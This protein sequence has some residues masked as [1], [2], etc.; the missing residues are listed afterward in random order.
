MA[1]R[2]Q[3]LLSSFGEEEGTS[4]F[5]YGSTATPCIRGQRESFSTLLTESSLSSEGSS[6]QS[7]PSMELKKLASR[8]DLVPS[9]EEHEAM[10]D[11]GISSDEEIGKANEKSDNVVT[12]R[13]FVWSMMKGNYKII[14]SCCMWYVSY[15][16]MSVLG[17]TVAFMHFPRT[18]LPYPRALPDYGY[19]VIPEWCPAVPHVPH[20]NVQSCI[21]LVLYSIIWSGICIRWNRDGKLILQQMLHLNTLVFLTRTTTVSVTGLPQPNPKC[22]AVQAFPVTYQQAWEFVVG[23][24]FPPHACGDLIYSGHVACTLVCMTIMH[25]HGFLCNRY[26]GIIVWGLACLGIFATLSC[27]S[28]YTV[29]VVLACYFVLFLKEFYFLRSNGIVNGTLA[30][31]IQWIERH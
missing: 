1:A 4:L 6:T 9:D 20:G 3:Q 30:R 15:M 8:S 10:G 23:R 12:E 21:L 13:H 24:G 7:S 22:T 28:H 27:R 16:I 2:E 17:G 26:I 19:D 25:R 29:D 31:W 5:T 18:N 11:L 14:L